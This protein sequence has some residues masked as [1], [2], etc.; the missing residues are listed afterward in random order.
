MT[1]RLHHRYVDVGDVRLHC[2][3][4][5]DGPLVILLHGF[6]EFWYSWRHQIPG[7]A[8]AGFRVV[9]P[10]M[11]GYNLSPKPRGRLSY[12]P[13]ALARDVATLT[14]ALGHERASV[15]GHDWGG[16]VGWFFAMWH[17]RHIERLVVIN[18]PHPLTYLR[19]LRTWRQLLKSWYVLFVQLPW[20]PEAATRAGDHALLRKV[21]RDEPVVAGA[22]TAEDIERYV[23][24]AARPGAMTSAMNYYRALQSH[25]GISMMRQLRVVEAPVLVIWGVKD[26]YLSAEL[27]VPDPRSA[28]YATV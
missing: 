20:V 18:A 27:A 2:V 3:E 19:A 28:P 10:D 1:A 14:T 17:P 9:A 11:R 16:I 21:L 8:E 13:R 7:L 26:R 4:A 15:V 12:T 22:F 25:A 23:E 5:G 24:A 6:P